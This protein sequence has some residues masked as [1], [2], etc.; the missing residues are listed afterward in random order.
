MDT[1]AADTGSKAGTAACAVIVPC[2]NEAERLQPSRFAEFLAQHQQVRLLFVNDGSSDETLRVL[3]AMRVAHPDHVEVL[4]IQPNGGK[5]EA[6]RHGML[7]MIAGG[8][9]AY[10]GYWDADLATP[11]NLIPELMS[12]LQEQPH[13][14][15]IFGA[16]VRLLGHAI[17]RSPIRHYLGRFFATGV[18]VVLGLPIYD[19]QCGAKIFKITPVLQSILAAPFQ[20][21]WIFDVEL[22][23]RFLAA[24]KSDP[25][26]ASKAIYERPLPQ[27]EDVAGSKVK[28]ADFFVAFYELIKIRK[29]YRHAMRG[30]RSTRKTSGAHAD[31][32]GHS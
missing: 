13:L 8:E 20:S 29:T 30:R 5:A 25:E 11:L 15:M 32:P 7:K 2:Y 19:T 24:H 14:E 28:P 3:E 31:V 21:R 17:H 6:V 22:I 26:F 9:V 4:D 16:R 23:A 27:W 10:T 1:F 18:S 12:K